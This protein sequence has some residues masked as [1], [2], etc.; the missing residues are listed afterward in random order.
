MATTE[1]EVKL[2]EREVTPDEMI[3]IADA[4]YNLAVENGSKGHSLGPFVS[5]P[6]ILRTIEEHNRLNQLNVY[7]LSNS[8]IGII[9]YEIGKP[10]WSDVKVLGEMSIF[11]VDNR[12]CGFGRIALERLT[13]IA[14]E[15]D[16]SLIE[17]GSV[18][19]NDHSLVKN[20]YMIKGKYDWTYPSYIKILQE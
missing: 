20:L 16:C 9:M 19:C 13:E 5:Y 6:A 4:M 18:I 12:F 17:T 2:L 14:V 11:T 3:V 8:I 10:W 7:A 15:N 1:V